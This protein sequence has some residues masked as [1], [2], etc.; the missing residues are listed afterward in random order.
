MPRD[1][2]RDSLLTKMKFPVLPASKESLFCTSSIRLARILFLGCALGGL[3]ASASA[4][5]SL[6]GRIDA[7]IAE[8]NVVGQAPIAG[9]ADY[10]RRTY[11]AFMD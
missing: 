11:L 6:H 7:M 4:E 5:G 9:D 3:A 10:L 8:A 1:Q 2:R